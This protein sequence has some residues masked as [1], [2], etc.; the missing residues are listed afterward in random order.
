MVG[1]IP[2]WLEKFL[3]GWKNSNMVGKKDREGYM[4]AIFTKLCEFK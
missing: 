4:K 1:T 2:T 3:H